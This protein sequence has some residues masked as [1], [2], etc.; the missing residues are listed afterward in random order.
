MVGNILDDLTRLTTTVDDYLVR[1][2]TVAIDFTE[3][4]YEI[5]AFYGYLGIPD[6][7]AEAATDRVTRLAAP[8]TRPTLWNL[9][10]SLLIALDAGY[11]GSRASDTFQ[12]YNEVAQQLLYQPGEVT[13]TRR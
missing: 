6:T 11:D 13:A 1:A 7:Y 5:P 2:R 10:L 9:Q 3:L 4:P 12:A 8:A